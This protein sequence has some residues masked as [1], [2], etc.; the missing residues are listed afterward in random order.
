MQVH[1]AR[2]FSLLLKG[3]EHETQRVNDVFHDFSINL[4]KTEFSAEIEKHEK[5]EVLGFPEESLWVMSWKDHLMQNQAQSIIR[6][7]NLI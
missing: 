2:Q 7:A 1:S 6:V 4:E 3:D 5:C